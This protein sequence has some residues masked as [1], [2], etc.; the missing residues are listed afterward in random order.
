MLRQRNNLGRFI[1]PRLATRIGPGVV[2]FVAGGLS[3]LTDI[4]HAAI[5][6]QMEAP[7]GLSRQGVRAGAQPRPAA[8]GTFGH[9]IIVPIVRCEIYRALAKN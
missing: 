2:A 3:A 9:R 1:Y 7:A 4:L 6:A 8:C 5:Q